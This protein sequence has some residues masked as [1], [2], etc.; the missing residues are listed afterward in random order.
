MNVSYVKRQIRRAGCCA[1]HK[2]LIGYVALCARARQIFNGSQIFAPTP[3]RGEEVGIGYLTTA[4]YYDW[5]ETTLRRKTV[6]FAERTYDFRAD[7]LFANFHIRKIEY[8][9]RNAESARFGEKLAENRI[10]RV[11]R[12]PKARGREITISKHTRAET[13]AN[14][15]IQFSADAGG[16][17]TRY[18]ISESRTPRGW[19]KKTKPAVFRG[20]RCAF[21]VLRSPGR[22]QFSRLV[23]L[24]DC[25]RCLLLLVGKMLRW[26]ISDL[27]KVVG[28]CFF[29][30]ATRKIEVFR[31]Y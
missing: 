9:R 14:K 12:R 5:R 30:F 21:R 15:K 24:E 22:V 10:A 2:Y 29:F 8:S 13:S 19:E 16:K 26:K 4:D 6:K 17:M 11:R 31:F 3:W 27:C 28:I 7:A 1:K 23:I 25:C 20:R 18:E